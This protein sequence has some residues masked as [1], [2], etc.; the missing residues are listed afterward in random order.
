MEA[1][2]VASALRSTWIS[3]FDVP[4]KITSDQGRQL[5]S[6]LFEELCRWLGITHLRTT[7]YHPES[8]GM[9]ERLHR[10]LKAAIKCHD[11]SN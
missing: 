8:N 9:V 4:L 11:T 3:R 5:E 1:A 2:T 7:A 10:Q 6:K